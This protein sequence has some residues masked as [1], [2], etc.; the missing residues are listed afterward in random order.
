MVVCITSG[1]LQMQANLNIVQEYFKSSPVSTGFFLFLLAVIT[2]D[3]LK[4]CLIYREE[5]WRFVSS[6]YIS[7][8]WKGWT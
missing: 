7:L 4:M 1:R 2:L 3:I 5:K 8:L 6:M